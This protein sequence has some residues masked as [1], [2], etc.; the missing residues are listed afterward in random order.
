MLIQHLNALTISALADPDCHSSLYGRWM[1]WA[2]VI[3]VSFALGTAWGL[4]L[5]GARRSRDDE[6]DEI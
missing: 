5:E 3:L 2:A 1:L 6:D 4:W